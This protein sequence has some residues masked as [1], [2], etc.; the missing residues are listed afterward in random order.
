MR[1]ELIE[2]EPKNNKLKIIL[3]FLI[4]I[5]FITVFS[6][7]GIH[8]AKVYNSKLIEKRKEKISNN[9]STIKEDE[10]NDNKNN[11]EQIIA[12]IEDREQVKTSLVPVYTDSSKKKMKNIYYTKTKIAYLTFDDG[13]SKVVTP[14]ILDLLK[15]QNI[16]ATFF[17]L[18]TNVNKNPDIVKRAYLEGHY[19]AN[20]GY[21]HNYS[22]IYAKPN[23]V[24]EEYNKT[25]KAIKK[26]IGNNDYSSH[27]F[28]FPGG[29]TGGR[30][31]KIKKEAGKILNEN[32]IS[33]V[34]W[35][36][37]TG[38]AEGANTKEKIIQNLKKYTENKGNIVVL[39]HDA[40]NKILTYETLNEVIDYLRDEGYTFDNFYTI[41]S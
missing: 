37:L 8:Y 30:Y 11:K 2:V 26:A 28:R 25:E 23:N 16:K 3:I 27:L 21:S 38:D 4:T 35:N 39:M 29:Y 33:Y 22:K 1:I 9:I 10:N 40:S 19:I 20:H 14:L 6:I 13:P 7:L 41:M 31:A 34:D 32:D 24:L 36:V 17:V 18:G 12:T 5:L 15:E